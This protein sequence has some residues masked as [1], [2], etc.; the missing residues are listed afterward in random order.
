MA[1][2]TSKAKRM[3][4]KR[5]VNAFSPPVPHARQVREARNFTITKEGLDEDDFERDLSKNP[6]GDFAIPSIV[7]SREAF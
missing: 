5:E 6:S 7:A 2:T 1:L 3:E 4:E